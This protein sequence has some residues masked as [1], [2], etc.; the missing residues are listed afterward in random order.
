[1]VALQ[2]VGI[3]HVGYNLAMK[4]RWI[5]RGLFIGLLLLCVV[6]WL[7]T[8]NSGGYLRGEVWAIHLWAGDITVAR[9]ASGPA[10]SDFQLYF[11]RSMLRGQWRQQGL[12][13][14][15]VQKGPLGMAV[16]VPFWF[17]IA[18]SSAIVWLVLRKTRPKI[19]P[20]KAFPVEAKQST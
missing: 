18:T 12:L 4:R 19:D 8:F 7:W 1:V 20:A 2:V 14:F 10:K 13:G 17:L 6:G 15:R 11:E 3:H 5:I 9:W 16:G